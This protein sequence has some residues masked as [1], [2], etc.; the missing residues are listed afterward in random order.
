MSAEPAGNNVLTQVTSN[1]ALADFTSWRVGGLAKFFIQPK[2]SETLAAFI[3]QLPSELKR[4]W[5]GLGSNLLVR[6]GGVDGIVICTRSMTQLT[7]LPDQM[8]Y[9]DAGVT[10]AKLARFCCQHGFSD[11]AFFAGIPGTVGGALAMN[12]GAF[13]G[14][15]WHWVRQVR[16]LTPAGKIVERSQ[17]EYVFEYRKVKHRA[18]IIAVADDR[19]ELNQEA[20]LGAY[21]QFPD[22][23]TTDG[24]EKI[25]ILLRKRAQTQPIGTL[26]CGSVYKNPQDAFAAQ[27]IERCGLKGKV[28]G[29]AVISDKH[30]NFIINR[31]KATSQD[32]EQLMFEIE[33][34]VYAKYNIQLD[35]EVRIIGSQSPVDSNARTGSV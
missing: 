26:N 7:L 29:D 5:I 8:I 10:C 2:D 31:G 21:F 9:A 28:I 35:R 15:T 19:S 27:L 12:A 14:E 25:K 34:A 33:N 20:F 24:L 23:H 17:S 32:I 22:T 18:E 11:G 6:D 1:V 16:V 3:Q 4:Y 13:G 30:A